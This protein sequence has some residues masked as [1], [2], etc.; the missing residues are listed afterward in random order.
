MV[1]GD[2]AP[3]HPQGMADRE[4]APTVA[5][6]HVVGDGAVRDDDALGEAHDAT[7][8][9]AADL[10]PADEQIDRPADDAGAAVVA[11]LAV[12]D[13][14]DAATAAA[15]AGGLVL[16]HDHVVELE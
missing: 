11:D 15:D 14:E 12:V 13:D 7:V 5:I 8:M 6:G 1:V 2:H 3:F 16:R 10:A 9:V 4:D